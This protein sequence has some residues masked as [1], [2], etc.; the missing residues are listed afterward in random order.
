MKWQRQYKRKL[1]DSTERVRERESLVTEPL[2][3]KKASQQH[4]WYRD[5]H[6][7][8]FLHILSSTGLFFSGALQAQS[9]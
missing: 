4:L 6:C 5:P 1:N 8:V 7:D 9:C 2:S 3:R